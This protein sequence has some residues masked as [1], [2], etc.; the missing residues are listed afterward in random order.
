MLNPLELQI[1]LKVQQPHNQH[2]PTLELALQLRAP[3]W[4]RER[5]DSRGPVGA[6]WSHWELSPGSAHLER[7]HL[8]EKTRVLRKFVQVFQHQRSLWPK[9]TV[10]GND[11]SNNS[12]F[13]L[14][15]LKCFW[16]GVSF[17]GKLSCL[18]PE[19]LGRLS[20]EEGEYLI[21]LVTRGDDSGEDVCRRA[22]EE[23]QKRPL[24]CIQGAEHGTAVMSKLGRSWMLCFSRN[25]TRAFWWHWVYTITC[26]P[27]TD[28]NLSSSLVDLL[29]KSTQAS[30]GVSNLT[31]VRRLNFLQ[32]VEVS[33]LMQAIL[34]E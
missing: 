14:Y 20:N 23:G 18:C 10:E 22:W 25:M 6:R 1:N 17:Q 5:N 3:C 4:R 27:C 13:L 26:I 16:F 7:G 34:S 31:S 24:A 15:I 30:G 21:A 19:D 28:R 33:F 9:Q 29:C 8:W 32:W 11:L 12:L 2:V